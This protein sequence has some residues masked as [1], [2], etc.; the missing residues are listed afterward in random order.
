MNILHTET[1]GGWGGQ[2]NKIVK[3]LV[4]TRELGHWVGL[5]CNPGTPIG[6]RAR[7]LNIPVYEY[8]MNQWTQFS[9]AIPYALDL[10]KRL[11]IDVL[12]T[13][14]SSDSWM[15][16]LAGRL[17]RR[18]PVLLRERHNRHTI[19]G[20]PSAFLHR[21][22]FHRVLAVSTTVRD[23]LVEDVGVAPGRVMVLNSVVD[24]DAFDAVTSSIRQE[25]EIPMQARVVGMFSILRVNKGIYDFVQM[26]ERLMP[27]HP[28]TYVVF[29]GKTN[30]DRI[31]ECNGRLE[32]AGVDLRR[33]RWTGFRP[34]VANVMKGYDV[35]VF[36]SHTEGWPNVLMEA[37]A[38]GLPIVSYDMRP[39]S[40]LVENGVNGYTGPFGDIE[41]LATRTGELLED[42]GRRRRMAATSYRMARERHDV[43]G[44]AGRIREILTAVKRG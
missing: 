16:G 18:R 38:S 19:V 40:D 8:P 1:L 2:Q 28:D 33:V 26:V 42:A 6:E 23:Y 22:V 30:P 41:A 25:L 4:A 24:V 29:G 35:L 7:E 37:M 14:S 43:S 9:T 10:I 20:W 13:H 3:E 5:L 12:I 31:A 11:N 21:R 36:P 17:S 27:R 34:D 15:G 32:A 44:L 39:M